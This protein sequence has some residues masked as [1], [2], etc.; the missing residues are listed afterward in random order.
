MTTI[1]KPIVIVGSGFAGI[2]AALKLKK[3]NPSCPL[4]L[5]D[6]KS[7]FVFK[8]LLYEV[9]SDEI[10]S[11]EVNPFFE[12]ILINS[13]ITFFRNEVT[14][15][16]FDN[17]L[18]EF[19]DKLQINY[20]YLVL[21]TGSTYNDFSIKGVNQFCYFF[22]TNKDQ[23]KLKKLLE[24]SINVNKNKDIFIVGGGPSG[25]ELGCK[26]Y[27]LYPNKF[28]INIL[29]LDSEILSKNKI[30]NRE[31]AEK[32]IKKR[33]IN[34]QL[35]TK[36]QEIT[37]EKIIATNDLNEDIIFHYHAV[38][39]TAGIKANLP[40]IE[41]DIKKRNGRLLVDKTLKLI[42]FKNVF[43]IG[44][45]AIIQDN[46]DLPITAQVAMQQGEYVAKSFNSILN[47]KPLLP[48]EFKDNGEM[49]SIGI[50]EASISG[51]GLTFSGK[52][53]FD[54]RRLIYASKMPSFQKTLRSTASW[55]LD[56]KYLLS[57]IFTK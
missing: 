10:K 7:Q 8:P 18:L 39:W 17:N 54:L 20:E 16:D 31:E 26:I 30:F 6:S 42:D 14:S 45:I 3:I 33:N 25:I 50:G 55:I 34:L 36:V 21:C 32:A 37:N 38:I 49:I 53:A 28:K 41:Q 27:D 23:N 12:D 24:K 1:R 47:D 22:N 52:T 51:L 43:A 48:F 19:K 40:S 56:K 57:K 11:W 44:D 2:N 9:L 5:V 15:I 46:L 13:G 4:I 29:E 35:N